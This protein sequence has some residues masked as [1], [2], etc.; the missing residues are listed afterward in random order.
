[1]RFLGRA[2][3]GL[4]VLA[5]AG[6]SSGLQ[7]AVEK[8]FWFTT[9]STRVSA[10]KIEPP[11][12]SQ[13]VKVPSTDYVLRVALAE[14]PGFQWQAGQAQDTSMV[15]NAAYEGRQACPTGVS[16]CVYG[17]AQQY[18]I[19]RSGTTKIVFSLVA[20]GGSTKSPTPAPSVSVAKDAPN[21]P[22]G[23]TAPPP[24]AEEGCVLGRV[25]LTVVVP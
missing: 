3:A 20:G 13:T 14:Y 15:Q 9:L 8:P 12:P 21:C 22:A 7:P 17:Q 5:T 4:A 16:G 19:L 25:T 23:I 2:A 18:L 6:C 1:M 11:T 24:S 10:G